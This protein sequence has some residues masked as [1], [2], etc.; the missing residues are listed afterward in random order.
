MPATVY[1]WNKAPF[2]RLLIAFISGILVQWHLQF[3]QTTLLI[4][5]GICLLI[6]LAYVVSPLSRKFQLA[7]VSGLFFLAMIAIAGALLVWVKD[8]RN[9]DQWVG[10]NYKNEG[11]IIATLAEPLVEKANSYKALADVKSIYQDKHV[12]SAAGQILLYF[13]KSDSVKELQYGSVIII[14]KP[15]QA[16]KNAGNPGGFNYQQYCLFKGITHQMFLSPNDFKIL[17]GTEKHFPEQQIYAIRTWVLSVIKKYIT[18]EKEQGLAEALLIGYK[19]DLDKNLVQAYSN[20]GV[21]HVIAISGLHL[22]LIYWL[23]LLF[24]KP[25]KKQRKLLCLRLLLILF[26]LWTF[27]LLA[28]G[29]PS[30]LRSAVMFSCIAFAEVIGRRNFIYNTLTCSAFLLLCINPFWLWDVGFQLSY[31]AVLSITIFFR[32]IHN[33]FAFENRILSFIWKLNAVTIA[34]QL[35]TLPISI[36]HFH[37]V[38]TLFLFTN[39]VTVPLS[40]AILMG[41]ILLC[42]IFFIEPL[43]A[44]V[45]KVLQFCI[46]LMNSYIELLDRASFSTW[47]NLSINTWQVIFLVAFIT[48]FCFWLMEKKKLALHLAMLCLLV[49]AAIRSGSMIA[50]AQQQKLIVYNVPRHQAID[51]VHGNTFAFIG[52][53]DLLLDDFIRNFHIQ[54]SRIVHRLQPSTTQLKG[55]DFIL[56]NKHVLILDATLHWLPAKERQTVDVMVL[57]KNPKVYISSLLRTFTVKQVVIDG[58]VP[59][60]KASLW[61]K[62]CDSL[63]IRCHN[64][65]DKGAFVMNL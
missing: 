63:Q 17:P 18:T 38:P 58:S 19:D 8:I 54:P 60:W 31:A 6:A 47:K 41:E 49:V 20:T 48:A 65:N 26:S 56:N 52:D 4:A 24:T 61:Q 27:S 16:I 34:A 33:W 42:S 45:G 12:R 5:F 22:G 14:A 39:L 1:V 21:V 28:G 64:V 35:L 11:Y 15:L 23:V 46:Y 53:S 51:I 9:N 30:V 3:S 55:K 29:Q 37:Q 57:S 10:K 36:Y 50:A 2:V 7:P 43:A 44:L 59:L 62:D 40:S 25:I 13:K 32:P